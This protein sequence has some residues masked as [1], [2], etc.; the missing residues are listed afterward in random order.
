MELS[1]ALTRVRQQILDDDGHDWLKH[2]C[3]LDSAAATQAT[4]YVRAGIASL[5][6][7]PSRDTVV[8]ERFFDE[9]GGMQLVIH[10]PFGS[11][12]NRAW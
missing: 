4:A 3:S 2:E 5:G 9:G 8:A 7:L 11:R 1:E 12:I 10:A 6:A